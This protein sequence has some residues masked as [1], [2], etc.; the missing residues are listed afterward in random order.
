VA[1]AI[2]AG[3]QI[4]ELTQIERSAALTFISAEVPGLSKHLLM[5]DSPRDTGSCKT[6]KQ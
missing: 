2:F 6:E 4:E 5:S 1:E 3:K